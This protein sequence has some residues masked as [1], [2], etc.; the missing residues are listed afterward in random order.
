MESPFIEHN[1]DEHFATDN[2]LCDN[3]SLSSD[4]FCW[5]SIDL[6]QDEMIF[7][8]SKHNDS[9]CQFH[10]DGYCDHHK[11]CPINNVTDDKHINHDIDNQL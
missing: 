1:Y 8:G 7:A 5:E 3:T 11:F 2:R 10:H 6:W 9:R 4:L